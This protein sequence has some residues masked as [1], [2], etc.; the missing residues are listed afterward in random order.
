[1]RATFSSSARKRFFRKKSGGHSFIARTSV[2]PAQ[3]I[4][5][6]LFLLFFSDPFSSL[7]SVLQYYSS[8]IGTPSLAAQCAKVVGFTWEGSEV[9]KCAEGKRGRRLLMGSVEA[10]SRAGV[11]KSATVLIGG[12][13]GRVAV[14][15]ALV[16]SLSSSSFFL[17]EV[18]DLILCVGSERRSAASTTASGRTAT[19]RS[20]LL[21]PSFLSLPLFRFRR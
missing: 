16:F 9:E 3:P 6:S 5:L 19:V 1:M 11:E 21:I 15:L 20:R 7:L 12:K 17:L 14:L 10:T 4:S 18:T 8:R 2:A 13:V